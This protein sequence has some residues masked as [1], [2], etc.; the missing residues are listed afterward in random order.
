LP[1][2]PGESNSNDY[3][4]ETRNA[5]HALRRTASPPLSLV[6]V[7]SY[8]MQQYARIKTRL[9]TAAVVFPVV[10]LAFFYLLVLRTRLAVGHWPY[11]GHPDPK[12]T[13]F[14]IH[15]FAVG[16]GLVAIPVFGLVA[17]ALGLFTW[18]RFRDVPWRLVLASFLVAVATILY[19]KTE[20]GDFIG[21]YMD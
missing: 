13:G 11:Y 5:I 17:S 12:D 4:S 3:L 19:L 7:A 16:L 8:A 14:D 20:P 6:Q 21:W 18:L 10:W 15:Y 9:L 1:D 2:L